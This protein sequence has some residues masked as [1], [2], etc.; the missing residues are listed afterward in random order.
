MKIIPPLHSRHLCLG[1]TDV[2]LNHGRQVH[3]ALVNLGNGCLKAAQA[4]E[5]QRGARVGDDKSGGSH[6]ELISILVKKAVRRQRPVSR[7]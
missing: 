6:S 2:R 5:L 3:P 1:V 4:A 7:V